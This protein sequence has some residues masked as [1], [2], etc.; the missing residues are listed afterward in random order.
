M[1][2]SIII[3][4]LNAERKILYE[5]DTARRFIAST[6]SS[7]EVVVVEYGSTDRTA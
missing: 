2:I 1:D 6:F 5:I 7:G 3:P 4:A